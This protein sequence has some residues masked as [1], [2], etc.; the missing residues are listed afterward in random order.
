MRPREFVLTPRDCLKKSGDVWKLTIM[1][2]K[3][4]G[5]HK[6]VAYKIEDDYQRVTYRIPD[7]MANLINWYI[8]ETK[9]Y[10]VN[11]L[12]T[13]FIADT[14]YEH[15]GCCTPY[16]SRYFTYVN[17]CTCLRYFFEQIVNERYNYQIVYDK[18]IA[19]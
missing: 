7:E 2:D 9:E 15:W 17:M 10:P 13:L 14:H 18:K 6:T 12:N 1:K 5:A 11:E 3:L 4:K 16:T 19:I 8:E